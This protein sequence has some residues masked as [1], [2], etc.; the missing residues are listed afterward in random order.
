M[1]KF[2]VNDELFFRT[3]VSVSPQYTH[4]LLFISYDF[5]LHIN[6]KYPTITL[7]FF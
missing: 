4:K 5:R 2:S 6:D 3:D 1:I 7:N